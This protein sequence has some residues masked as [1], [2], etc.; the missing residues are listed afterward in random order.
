MCGVALFQLGANVTRR[1]L[2]KIVVGA[3]G[4]TINTTGGPHFADVPASN[5]FYPFVETALAHGIISGYAD[6]TFPV[7][8]NATRD[9]T[10]KIVYIA[11]TAP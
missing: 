10:S 2:N 3:Q 5:P 4:W 1:Q 8:A 6:G 7:G 9:Q 11:L